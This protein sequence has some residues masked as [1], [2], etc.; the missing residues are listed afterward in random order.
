MVSAVLGVTMNIFCIERHYIIGEEER[1]F[2]ASYHETYL[3]RLRESDDARL[4]WYAQS[5]HG[6]GE[7]YCHVSITAFKGLSA[8]ERWAE[9]LR[10]GDLADWLEEAD[11]RRYRSD[12]SLYVDAAD[13]PTLRGDWPS[14][15]GPDREPVLLRLDTISCKED[16]DFRWNSAS[17]ENRKSAVLELVAVLRPVLGHLEEPSVSLLY[18]VG[19]HEDVVAAF[20]SDLGDAQWPGALDWLPTNAVHAGTRLLRTTAW[21]PLS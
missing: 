14:G 9:R 8:W 10:R 19:H 7:A 16:L 1:S 13:S 20:D 6:A 4:L 3:P 11:S 15:D 2:E 18:R 5:P 21:S 12:G 17:E